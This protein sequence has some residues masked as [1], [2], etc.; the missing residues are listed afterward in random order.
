[1]SKQNSQEIVKSDKSKTKTS[2]TEKKNCKN[3][4]VNTINEK[5][6]PDSKLRVGGNSKSF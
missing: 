6:L 2:E 4:K 3:T 5:T 1:M